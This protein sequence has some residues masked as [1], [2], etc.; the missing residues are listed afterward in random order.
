MKRSVLD[1]ESQ[2]TGLAKLSTEH[3]G[4]MSVLR[5]KLCTILSGCVL[6]PRGRVGAGKV[7]KNSGSP[8]EGEKVNGSSER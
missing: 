8:W 6:D 7:H 2:K 1:K 5:E 4:S 3:K